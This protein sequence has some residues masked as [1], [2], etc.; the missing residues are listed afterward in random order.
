MLALGNNIVDENLLEKTI[1][2]GIVESEKG[3]EHNIKRM[4]AA[5][6][7]FK[8]ATGDFDV[9]FVKNFLAS[10]QNYPHSLCNDGNASSMI[11]QPSRDKKSVLIA[12]RFPC[13]SPYEKCS[14][15]P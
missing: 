7:M 10:H 14:V 8:N 1:A 6:E 12:E 4:A 13:R 3:N 2:I 15:L 5:E 9:D 11:A